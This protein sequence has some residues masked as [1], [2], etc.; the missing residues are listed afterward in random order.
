MFWP[1]HIVVFLVNATLGGLS[2]G[3]LDSGMTSQEVVEQP[4]LAQ[5]RTLPAE[6]AQ[7]P[8]DESTMVELGAEPGSEGP[9]K[10]KCCNKGLSTLPNPGFGNLL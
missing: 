3:E 2:P 1:V 7:A 10:L 6:E 8:S 5:E 9:D 4:Q